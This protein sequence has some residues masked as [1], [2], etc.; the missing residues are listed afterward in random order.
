MEFVD[1]G[2]PKTPVIAVS[3]SPSLGADPPPDREFFSSSLLQFD[4]D[5]GGFPSPSSATLRLR[6]KEEEEEE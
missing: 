3:S 1:P 4:R 2:S 6:E 5:S